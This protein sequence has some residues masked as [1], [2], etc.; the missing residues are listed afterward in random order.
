MC[1]F[2]ARRCKLHALAL[3]SQLEQRHA[4]WHRMFMDCNP[5]IC[6]CADRCDLDSHHQCRILLQANFKIN[7]AIPAHTSACNAAQP[8]GMQPASTHESHHL[9]LCIALCPAR[10]P[11]SCIGNQL[12]PVQAGAVNLVAFQ[13]AIIDK[14]LKT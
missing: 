1:C 10:V 4:H 7:C 6:I 2:M 3:V 11:R 14:E 13:L 8:A 9:Q 5:N 12:V